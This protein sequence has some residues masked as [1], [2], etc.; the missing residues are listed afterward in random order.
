M[1]PVTRRGLPAGGHRARSRRWER[2][3]IDESTVIGVFPIFSIHT[4]VG[5]AA[6]SPVAHRK[7][8][9]RFNGSGVSAFAACNFFP[10]A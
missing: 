7:R 5:E 2:R 1:A 10:S 6:A 3:N 8:W 4:Q 9:R